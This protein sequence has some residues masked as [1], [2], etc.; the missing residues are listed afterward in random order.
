MVAQK[1][2]H[3]CT[4]HTLL[5]IRWS[6]G[7]HFETIRVAQADHI[8]A[9][10]VSVQRTVSVVRLVESGPAGFHCE[11]VFRGEPALLDG[12]RKSGWDVRRMDGGPLAPSEAVERRHIRQEVNVV[13]QERIECQT[14]LD[15]RDGG[16]RIADNLAR[17][18]T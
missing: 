8:L 2:W 6:V 4:F 1:A 5:F 14:L 13:G 15:E 16:T 10:G 9:Y 7:F 17:H 12:N 11:R 18:D 3:I